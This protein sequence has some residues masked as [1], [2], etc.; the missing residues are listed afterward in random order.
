MNSS[1]SRN[2]NADTMTTVLI[3]TE[4]SDDDAYIASGNSS[5][6]D[7]S[8][9]TDDLFSQG[10]LEGML[11]DHVLGSMKDEC[12]WVLDMLNSVDQRF[13]DLHSL[14]KENSCQTRKTLTKLLWIIN[15]PSETAS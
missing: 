14:F 3:E 2:G 9:Q 4:E 13:H 6:Q 8:T 10:M 12:P 11:P 7:Q 5:G 1:D 15:T